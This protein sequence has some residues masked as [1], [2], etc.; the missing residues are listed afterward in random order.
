MKRTLAF[1]LAAIL[2]LV[3][4]PVLGEEVQVTDAETAAAAMDEQMLNNSYT[5]AYNA[6]NAGDFE[7]AKAYI[8]LCFAYCDRQTD[9][10]MVSDL[11]LKLGYI[12]RQEENLDLALLY[13]DA[14]LRV[15]PDYA[16]AYILKADIYMAAGKNDKAVE[17]LE[18]YI[19]LSQ[20]TSMY[21]EEAKLLEAMGNI[22]AAQEAYNKYAQGAGAED[23]EAGFENGRYMMRVE[24]Y[25]EAI[26]AFEAY[27][28]NETYAAGAYYN[29]AMC[30]FG[31]KDYAGSV[32]AYTKCEELGGLFEGLYYNRGI[33]YF[34]AENWAE[35]E[36][37]FVKSIENNEYADLEEYAGNAQYFRAICRM[38]LGDFEGAVG[39]F[40]EC[41]GDGEKTGEETEQAEGEPA[42]GKTIN[43]GA[44]YY[45]A[46]CEE[47]LGQHE[48]ALA[49]ITVCIDYGFE[50]RKS[51][52]MRAQIYGEL[53]DIEKQNADIDQAMKSDE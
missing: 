43:L 41:I 22:E 47:E 50:L 40:T 34:F 8:A 25:E 44:Y 37:D 53:G 32:E 20:D 27:L 36:K 29:I 1:V 49:D 17:N 9:P 42:E 39:L 23:E 46:T 51:Y 14:A 18:K 30:K 15:Q 16:N 26:T 48:A 33:S 11:L 38:S 19:E 13:M 10:V 45:R 21:Q 52:S 12:A 24:K 7:T 28:D 3:A 4:I 2:L 5:R 6:I 31:L 35:A